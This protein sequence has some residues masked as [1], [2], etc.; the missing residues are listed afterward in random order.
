V[1]IWRRLQGVGAIAIKNSVYALPLSDQSHEDLKWISQ[2]I[3][4]NNGEATI[5]EA[6]F[7]DGMTDVDVERL[8]NAARDEEYAALAEEAARVMSGVSKGPVR[9]AGARSALEND[10]QRLRRRLATIV[11]TDYFSAQGRPP[12]ESSV[13]RLEEKLKDPEPAREAGSVRLDQ[14]RKRVWVT[15]KGIHVDRIASAWLIRRF[16]DPE[17]AFRFV[18]DRSFEPTDGELRFDMFN[19]EFTH[20]GDLC[21]FEVLL[22]RFKLGDPALR[23]I[24]EIIHDIDLKETKFGRPETAGFERLVAGIAVG[25]REDE[26]RLARGGAVLD[27]L[28]E[29]FR[30]YPA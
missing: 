14:C 5:C 9:D 8:F 10:I 15:R 22:A 28:H 27:D 21:T 29:A 23:A 3:Q 1:K 25:H 24:A 4:K 2:E 18:A 11:K 13:V 6:Q 7:V 17:A 19:G 30:R 12:A 16:I 26:D 20:E